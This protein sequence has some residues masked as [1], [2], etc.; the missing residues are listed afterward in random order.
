M[1]SWQ[2]STWLVTGGCG[3]IGT[4]LVQRLCQA[5]RQV[6]VFDNFS[7][8]NTA[9]DSRAEIIEGDVR[10]REAIGAAVD[11]CDVVIHL[12]AQSGVIPSIED[13]QKDFDVNSI[14]TLNLLLSCRDAGAKRVVFA[15]SNA[16]LGDVPSPFEE[17]K[18]PHP[19]SPYGASKLVGEAYCLAFAGSYDLPTVALRF[20][21]VYGPLS[22]HKSSVVARFLKR[23]L[24][25]QPLIIYGDGSQTRDFIH[26]DDLC[27]AILLAAEADCAGE[28]FH[29]A[30]GVEVGIL[31][32]ARLIRD[33][34]DED[35]P[36]V[37]EERRQGEAYRI[38][39]SIEKANK[40]LGFS[41]KVDIEEGVRRTY[42]WFAE[43]Y[44]QSE[45]VRERTLP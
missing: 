1:S 15:S 29:I 45:A 13:P 7:V 44:Q 20:A 43:H 24:E 16:A 33:A 27:D 4:N 18:A 38:R 14:G 32:L 42:D 34:V 35:I 37:H 10:D 17:T 28:I 30:S 21:N 9:P 5:D 36:I 22:S 31:D 2:D 41:P 3:F 25:G 19:I 40:L 11:G 39:A 12:A 8:G 23:A 26:V 6:R